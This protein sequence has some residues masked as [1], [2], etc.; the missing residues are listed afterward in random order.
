VDLG[1]QPGDT[2]QTITVTEQLPL[3]ETTNATLG[4]TLSNQTINDLPLNGRNYINLLILRPGITVYA[5]G[6]N[7]PARRMGLEWKTLAICW[8]V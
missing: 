6:G 3:I 4:G 8:M 7:E 2:T 1:L 5:G